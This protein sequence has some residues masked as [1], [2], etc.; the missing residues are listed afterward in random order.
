MK[1][2]RRRGT[3]AGPVDCG[4]QLVGTVLSQ[5]SSDLALAWVAPD[6]NFNIEI[7]RTVNG[8]PFEL[9][10]T[11]W[12]ASE[13]LF[14]GGAGG[15]VTDDEVIYWAYRTGSAQSCAVGSNTVVWVEV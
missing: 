2:W 7:Y 4:Q 5:V 12:D 8:G 3:R 13:E 6:P 10:A 15:L 11:G 14:E 1:H 9:V